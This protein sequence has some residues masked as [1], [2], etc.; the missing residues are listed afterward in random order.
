MAKKK[1]TKG[2][3]RESAEKVWLAGLGALAT[4]E[5]E[6]SKA[7]KSLVTKGERYQKALKEPVDRATRRM[8]GTVRDVRG[9]AAGT[10]RKVEDLFDHQVTSAL[11]RLGVPTRGEVADLTRRVEA[12]TRKLQATSGTTPRP[13]RKKRAPA[14]KKVVRRKTE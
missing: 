4:A 7:F 2:D 10:I 8:S 5:E 11:H 3:L 9:R 14:R 6:G 1:A 12:L 13:A